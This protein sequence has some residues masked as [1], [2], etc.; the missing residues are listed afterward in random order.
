MKALS[1]IGRIIFGGFFLY[2]GIN[3]F[4]QRQALSQYAGSKNVPNPDLAVIA[5]GVTLAL[6]GTSMVLGLKPKLG[7]AGIAAFLGSVSPIMHDFWS[8]EDPNQRQSDLYHFSKN[9]AML[10]AA[11][12]LMGSKER[13][14]ASLCS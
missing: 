11:L 1:V 10:G 3:H 13:W 5:S 14:P 6:A 9:M 12:L 8:A 2:N 7:A 4:M